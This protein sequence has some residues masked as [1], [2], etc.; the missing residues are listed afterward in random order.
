MQ[1]VTESGRVFKRNLGNLGSFHTK[2]KDGIG[3]GFTPGRR[4]ES[5][6]GLDQQE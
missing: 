1:K 5:G 4:T 6:P 3:S 2:K